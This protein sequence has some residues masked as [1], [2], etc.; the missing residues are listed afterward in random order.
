VRVL[1]PLL[2]R[3]YYLAAVVTAGLLWVAAFGL[4]VFRFWPILSRPRADGR[5]G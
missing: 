2:V 4:F 5:A 1:V 3:Q